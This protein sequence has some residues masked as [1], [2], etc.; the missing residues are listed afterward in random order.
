MADETKLRAVRAAAARHRLKTT[1]VLD[2]PS[3]PGGSFLTPNVR[4]YLVE[5]IATTI[6]ERGNEIDIR[7]AWFLGQSAFRLSGVEGCHRTYVWMPRLLQLIVMPCAI[8]GRRATRRVGMVG[9]CRTHRTQ[10]TVDREMRMRIAN[11]GKSEKNLM[12]AMRE[13]AMDAARKHH[14]ARGKR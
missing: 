9:F 14:Q 7:D 4:A 1:G 6:V 11:I 5:C 13:R 2:T 8:C 10:A 12:I 3:T